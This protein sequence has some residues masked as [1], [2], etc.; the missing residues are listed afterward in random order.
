[1][2]KINL[3]SILSDDKNAVE[4]I[5]ETVEVA[6]QPLPDFDAILMEWSWRC[7]KGYP[8]FNNK[9]DMVALKE[10]LKEMNLSEIDIQGVGLN[11]LDEAKAAKIPTSS[12]FN[13]DYLNGKDLYPKY[14]AGI[15]K[16]Y[17][18]AGADEI[19]K[20]LPLFGNITNITDLINTIKAY[21]TNKLFQGLYNI[22]SVS[23]KEGGEADTSG[24]G[25]LGKGEVLCVLLTKSGKSGGTSGTD[26][27]GGITSEIKAGTAKTFKVPLAASRITAFE[28][29]KQL[30]RLYSLIETVKEN[31]ALYEQFLE[32]IQAELGSDKMKLDDGVYFAKKSTPSNINQTEYTNIRKFFKG[33]YN[34]FYVKN[35]KLD[36][37]I[38]VDLDS[39]S[40]GDADVLLLAKLLSPDAISSIKVGTK[41]QIEVQSVEKD[42]VRAFQL[43]SY[44]LKQHPY[45]VDPLA[46]DS[47]TETDLNGLLA[48]NYLVFHE[49]SAGVL[50]TPILINKTGDQYNARVVGYT[51][52]QVIVKFEP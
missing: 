29:Q 52:D 1:M 51:L 8:D 13:A 21:K 19:N 42:E 44:R 22:S 48:N 23:G 34:Y 41:V 11:Q 45:V 47:A 46:F 35:K 3:N 28:S 24:R 43:F 20:V 40:P 33:C 25:G 14:S 26:L 12:I 6:Q 5:E 32:D 10:V 49:P 16:A 27:D 50:N 39:D 18:D 7:E 17:R 37:S 31:K 36:N 9:K 4:R 15:M 2:A 38:Y 30:R